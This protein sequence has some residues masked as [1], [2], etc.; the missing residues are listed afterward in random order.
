MR[1]GVLVW[2]ILG[3]FLAVNVGF[4]LVGSVEHTRSSPKTALDDYVAKADSTYSWRLV[5][6]IQ[7]DGYTI[8]L[9]D[10]KSQSWRSHPEVNRPVWKHQL[11]LVKPDVIEHETAFLNI[12]D[13]DAGSTRNERSFYDVAITFALATNSVVAVLD[14]VPNQALIFNNDGIPRDDDDLIAYGQEKFMQTLDPTWL[15]RLPMVKSVVRAMDTITELMGR[16]QAGGLHIRSFVVE[17]NSKRGWTTWL[18]AA[19]DPRVIAIVPVVVD[20]LNIPAC[21]AHH[22]RSYGFWAP[23]LKDYSNHHILERVESDSFASIMNIEDPYRY[24]DRLTMPKYLVNSAGDEYFPPD[25]S[26]FYY[27]DLKGPTYLR[28]VPNTDHSLDPSDAIESLLPFYQAILNDTPLPQFSLRMPPDGS[29]EVRTDD[30]PLEVTLW[31]ATNPKSRDFRFETI[32]PAY[33]KSVLKPVG[34]GIYVAK[35]N[36]PAQGWTAFFVEMIYPNPNGNV[37]FKFT[38]QVRIV[39]DVLP[40]SLDALKAGTSAR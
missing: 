29:I 35:V 8:F 23:A 11:F 38:S 20:I 6:T 22:F 34:Q 19:V 16:D 40:Y 4:I 36:R 24:R 33:Q 13:Y 1:P 26:Q 3:C 32:G 18:T 12:S 27:N 37:P 10:L 39:P 21:L 7:G 14:N 5:T 30:K 28:Y 25:S 2:C 15:P 31:Q 9:V 17:G